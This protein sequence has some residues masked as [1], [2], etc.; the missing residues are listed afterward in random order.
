MLSFFLFIYNKEYKCLDDGLQ[1]IISQRLNCRSL[2]YDV[3]RINNGFLYVLPQKN[4]KIY[5]SN[6]PSKDFIQIDDNKMPITRNTNFRDVIYELQDIRKFKYLG[7]KYYLFSMNPMLG[8]NGQTVN[9]I[10]NAATKGNAHIIFNEVNYNDDLATSIG[11]NKGELFLLNQQ[12]DSVHYFG[13]KGGR[14]K[15]DK[16]RSV[17]CKYDST[18]KVCVPIGYC[19]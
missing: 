9:I 16:N 2:S 14:F 18:Y 17:K 5:L 15:Y 6:N 7:K 4:V 19:W 11:I 1:D 13:L 8:K 3:E 10:I 12:I